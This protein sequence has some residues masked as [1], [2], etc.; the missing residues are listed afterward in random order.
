MCLPNTT[1]EHW[2]PISETEGAYSV[3]CHGR[4]RRDKAGAGALAGRIL[5]AS[6]MPRHYRVV[7]LYLQG[8]RR[9]R[10]VPPLVAAAFLGPRP[11]GLVINHK[12]GRKHNDYADNLEYVTASE[13]LRHAARM[14]LSRSL[15]GEGNPRARL[16]ERAV[17]FIRNSATPSLVLAKHYGVSE[18]AV[19]S[20]RVGITWKH[21]A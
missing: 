21:I 10:R 16:T 13:N 11:E 15:K 4:V 1:T 18:S 17:R 5:R 19:R 14:G 12:D 3:S 7:S 6:G 9:E 8:N 20:A 2:A